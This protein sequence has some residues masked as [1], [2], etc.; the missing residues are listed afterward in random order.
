MADSTASQQPATDEARIV[1]LVAVGLPAATV[2]SAI[3][4][5]FVIGPATSILVLAAGTL[6][7]V[8]SLFWGSI[9]ILSGD[10]PLDPELES[11][12]TDAGGNPL[13]NRRKMLLRAL[14]DVET[15]RNLGKIAPDDYELIIATYRA[16]LKVVLRRIDETLAPHRAQAEELAREHLLQAGVATP[17]AEEPPVA[18]TA[19]KKSGKPTTTAPAV[20]T[21]LPCPS[22]GASNEP[23]AKFC[24]ECAASLVKH[25]V[26]EKVEDAEA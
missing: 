1:R 25:T 7:G 6:L 13:A 9:R 2:A 5:A 12:D 8:I 17:I 23:D 14:K 21:R 20:D 3:V 11:L 4:V 24:K 26:T 19:K 15:E 16:E 22:C 18:K 10:A